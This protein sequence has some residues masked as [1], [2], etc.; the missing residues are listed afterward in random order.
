[1]YPILK[2]GH[3]F[4]HHVKNLP[5]NSDL[6]HIFLVFRI[7]IFIIFLV[8]STGDLIFFYNFSNTFFYFLQIVHVFKNQTTLDNIIVKCLLVSLVLF[9]YIWQLHDLQKLLHLLKKVPKGLLIFKIEIKSLDFKIVFKL[10]SVCK[11][12]EVVEMMK[13]TEQLFFKFII[14]IIYV[15]LSVKAFQICSLSFKIVLNFTN[16]KNSVIFL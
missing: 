2:L 14:N 1:M 9:L 5:N 4:Y 10:N 15:V 8:G 13:I 11:N 16:I 3:V 7:F 6:I 12:V